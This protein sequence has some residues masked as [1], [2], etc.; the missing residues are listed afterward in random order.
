MRCSPIFI[1]LMIDFATE[2]AVKEWLLGIHVEL[3]LIDGD[4]R[5]LRVWMGR[6]RP[7]TLS[8]LWVVRLLSHP[9]WPKLPL[10]ERGCQLCDCF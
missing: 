7:P 1:P 9:S 5:L 10:F 6:L 4:I 8:H 2:R 3:G